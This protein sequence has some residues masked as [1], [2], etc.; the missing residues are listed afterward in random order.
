M[1]LRCHRESIISGFRPKGVFRQG[2]FRLRGKLI[3][4][5]KG[6]EFYGTNTKPINAGMVFPFFLFFV[7]AIILTTSGKL[8]AQWEPVITLPGPICTVY[9]MDQVGKPE[10]GFISAYWNQLVKFD[11]NHYL[12]RTSD[13]GMTWRGLDIPPADTEPWLR[14]GARDFAFKDSLNGWMANYINFQTTDAGLSWIPMSP[15]ING[16]AD[17]DWAIAYNSETKLLFCSRITNGVGA[18]DTAKSSSD[19][20]T[21]WKAL[22]PLCSYN[23]YAFSGLNGIVTGLESIPVPALYTTDGGYTWL[24]SN[25]SDECY[26]PACI[27]GT[28]TFVAESEL[29]HRISR[30]DD[31]G[32]TW[33]TIFTLNNYPSAYSSSGCI[34]TDDCG[35]LYVV[36]FEGFFMSSDA[37]DSWH[38]I[39]GPA[40]WKD[41]RFWVTKDY[42]YAADQKDVAMY[43]QYPSTVW[44]YPL[45]NRVTFALTDSSK[46]TSIKPGTDVSVNIPVEI[47]QSLGSDSLHLVIRFDTAPLELKNILL[48]GGLS[49]IDSSSNDDT[50]N[51]W[52]VLDSNQV[53]RS[54][55]IGLTFKT[56]LNS[57]TAKIH[58]DSTQFYGGCATCN[59][60]LAVSHP[61]SVQINF[62]ACGDSLLLAAMNGR[63]LFTI[64]SIQPN[65]AADEIMVQLSGNVQPVI[66]MYDALGR[67][68]LAQRTTP[69]PLLL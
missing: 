4:D 51:L 18:T 21:T 19:D 57:P 64:E 6:R 65:P 33:R 54:P 30:S 8:Y 20:G 38:S 35:N 34:R 40:E 63:P 47:N 39:G 12:W 37:G 24:E 9:F 58:L 17:E 60:A 52:L 62:N 23:G 7:A 36:T 28:N 27:P 14:G 46:L 13:A 50:L 56:F 61:D 49:L 69:S 68:V 45:H 41:V 10:I 5:L 67:S 53:S 1:C 22:A 31:G 11:T 59:C 16:P 26:Q 32:K 29:M 42:I 48:T 55:N 43:D 25:F 3:A 66:E 15:D 44:R 2:G